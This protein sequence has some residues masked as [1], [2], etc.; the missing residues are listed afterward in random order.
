MLKTRKELKEEYKQMKFPKGVFQIRNLKNGK[1]F[2]SSSSDLNSSWNSQKFKLNAGMHPN[3]FL[4]QDW[5]E[6]REENFVYEVLEIIEDTDEKLVDPMDIKALESILI[7]Q[8]Q[9][10]SEKGYH[11][12]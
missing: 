11:K 9:P 3:S 2:I 1:V 7:E 8:T 10:Y 6:M 12:K 5:K 4:Q